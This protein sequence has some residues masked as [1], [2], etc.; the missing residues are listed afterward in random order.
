M[1]LKALRIQ[2]GHIR[3]YEFANKV[4]ITRQYLSMLETGKA[5]N[6]SIK[7]VKKIASELGVAPEE[8]FFG[9]E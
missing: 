1:N 8:I 3:A 4:G 7:V 9:G 6:P 2:K 5:V